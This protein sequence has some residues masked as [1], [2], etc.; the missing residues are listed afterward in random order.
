MSFL[1]NDIKTWV[2]VFINEEKNKAP[3][4][5]ERA[6][7]AEFTLGFLKVF[8]DA[9]HKKA[10]H[11]FKVPIGKNGRLF[12]LWKIPEFS[13]EIVMRLLRLTIK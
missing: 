8:G 9:D 10:I 3:V 4:T 1:W 13:H 11:E 2:D 6:Q 7:G 5:R 12:F